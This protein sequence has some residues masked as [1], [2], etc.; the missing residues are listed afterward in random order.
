MSW[1]V[2]STC[3]HR[4]SAASCA[5]TAIVDGSEKDARGLDL[6]PFAAGVAV[7]RNVAEPLHYVNSSTRHG[8]QAG[9]PHL[10]THRC[11]KFAVLPVTVAWAH[12]VRN[13]PASPG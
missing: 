13:W 4:P 12:Q 6:H 10:R 7:G 1:P 9:I 3:A 8:R 2:S 11:F 5:G